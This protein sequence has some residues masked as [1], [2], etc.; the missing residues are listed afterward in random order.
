M[1]AKEIIERNTIKLVNERLLEKTSEKILIDRANPAIFEPV[2]RYVTIG[3][4][5]P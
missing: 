4:G 5:E 3:I 2:D 1:E